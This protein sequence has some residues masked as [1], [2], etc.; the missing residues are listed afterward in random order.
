MPRT[1][2][3]E[4]VKRANYNVRCG[5]SCVAGSNRDGI[6]A[7]VRTSFGSFKVN[8]SHKAVEKAGAAALRRYSK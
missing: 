5:R 7:N 2:S 8:V 6:T 1:I 4:S 3:I